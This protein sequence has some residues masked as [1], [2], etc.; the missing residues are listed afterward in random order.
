MNYHFWGLSW[1]K[2]V[3]I[4]CFACLN[5]IFWKLNTG[6]SF[7]YQNYC[8]GTDYQVTVLY[9][10]S[11]SAC[12]SP[13]WLSVEVT[14]L[15]SVCFTLGPLYIGVSLPFCPLAESLYWS[16][17]Q[18]TW[19]IFPWQWSHYIPSHR[20]ADTHPSTLRQQKTELRPW[21]LH[22][23]IL[24]VKPRDPWYFWITAAKFGVICW[25]PQY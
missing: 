25:W 2:I 23:C 5:M 20:K 3:A 4:Y 12:Q 16:H 19:C 24:H 18:C 8:S 1:T 13:P 10:M 9:K 21:E 7:L 6:S 15:P 14:A 22:F 11:E 17:S